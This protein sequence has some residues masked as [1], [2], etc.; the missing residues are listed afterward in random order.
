MP[1]SII[2]KVMLLW[3]FIL[4][5]TIYL[6]AHSCWQQHLLFETGYLPL[7]L[8]ITSVT[9][10]LAIILI[11]KHAAILSLSGISPKLAVTQAE[12][13]YHQARIASKIQEHFT[14]SYEEYSTEQFIGFLMDTNIG[15]SS[16]ASFKFIANAAFRVTNTI[17]TEKP[18]GKEKVSVE[19][20]FICIFLSVLICLR[21]WWSC[22]LFL[23]RHLNG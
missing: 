8:L 18:I 5:L 1:L 16:L 6:L 20:G 7:T 9:F 23:L 22:Y 17:K 14:A 21:T 13:K 11:F 12:S 15:L 19:W 2:K 10:Q 3:W 4:F